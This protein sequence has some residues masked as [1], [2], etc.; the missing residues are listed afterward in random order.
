MRL[1]FPI[2]ITAANIARFILSLLIAF[3]IWAF[4]VNERDPDQTRVIQDVEIEVVGLREDLKI[5]DPLPTV[6]VTIK[7]PRSIVQGVTADDI[8]ATID[9]SDV[10]APDTYERP[11]KVEAPEGLR[12]I[13]VEP[14]TVVVRVDSEVSKTF[15]ITVV[16]PTDSPV[17]LTSIGLSTPTVT[18]VGVQRNVERVE[19]V[20][21]RVLLSGRTESFSYTA[22]V[23]PVDINGTDIDDDTVEV[24]PESVQVSVEFEVG[25]RSIPVIVQC[26]CPTE[27]GGVEIRDLQN[28]T[29]IPPT[30]RIEGPQPVL[31]DINVIRTMPVNVEDLQ[32]SDFVDG[33]VELDV[34]DLPD[35]VTIER[36]AVNVYVQIEPSIQEVLQQEIQIINAPANTVAN[37]SSPSVSFQI[38]GTVEALARMGDTPPTAI[39]DLTGYDVGTYTLSPRIVLPPGVRVVN[40][41]PAQ[42]QV[43]IE[44]APSP[45]PTSAPA[46]Q[47]NGDGAAS[48]SFAMRTSDARPTMS[49]ADN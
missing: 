23:I 5:V 37:V 2:R 24:V 1:Q 30:V 39:I 4:V 14:S 8:K 41:Q 43:T 11:V 36:P 13:D 21:V 19:R 33:A 6:D 10:D 12:D 42:I 18:L 20:E 26:A 25:S 46:V 31:A 9:M 47:P 32:V 49:T 16:E 35:G 17:T 44:R 40:L 15:D 22:P 7:G 48:S 3:G 34:S 28:A 38:E 29:A 27:G 45:A